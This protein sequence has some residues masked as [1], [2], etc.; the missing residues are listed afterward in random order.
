MDR[1]YDVVMLKKETYITQS[2]GEL[3]E[4]GKKIVDT[5]T[6][7]NAPVKI[8]DAREGLRQFHYYLELKKP[9]RMKAMAGFREDLCYA[10]SNKSVEIIA[11]IPD[12]KLIGVTVAKRTKLQEISPFDAY[13]TKEYRESSALTVPLGIDEFGVRMDANIARMPHA[14]IAGTT[15][16]GKSILLQIIISGLIEKNSPDEV[17]FIF[18]DPKRVE[19][20]LYNKLPHMLTPCITNAKKAVQALSWAVK[21][22]ERRYDIL[23]AERKMNISSYHE[24]VYKPAM[25]EWN[26]NGSKDQEKHLL[27]ESL[28]FIVIMIDEMNDIMQ[29]YPREVEAC[30]IRLAQMSRAVGIHL[31]LATQRPS[32]NVITGAVKANIPTRI[33]LMTASQVDSRTII[34]TPGTEKL[35]GRGDMLYL[36]SDEPRPTRA[37]SF[38]ISEDEIKEQVKR[39]VE[40]YSTDDLDSINFDGD[41][42]AND[43]IFRAMT[44]EF[45]DDDDELY[46]DA[47]Q[48]VIEAGKA[49]T[50]YIQRKLRV[51]YSRACRL[52]D[53]LEEKGVIGP[54]K[55]S[56]PRAVARPSDPEECESC[57]NHNFCMKHDPLLEIQYDLAKKAVIEKG[58]AS[59]SFLQR[60][61][62]IGYARAAALID[63]LEQNGVVGPAK[64]SKPRD[65]LIDDE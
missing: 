54:A 58:K 25:E 50:S 22:M 55:G 38:Y 11:P 24:S 29:A 42:D 45:E 35:E 3:K 33:G 20:T 46:E 65:V 6:A 27:P 52:M 40:K 34:D 32:V 39:S 57:A 37:Q 30:I 53:L 49:S 61:F 64:G 13:K 62:K 18:I 19:L 36:P 17:R 2:R 8:V 14:L 43:L 63:L 48:A 51:G 60:Q 26:K 47:K 4:I 1:E 5:L 16:S 7:F 23:E 9:V 59:T 41:R 44:G 31:I 21:E 10:L 56:K 28:P 12:K 15:G